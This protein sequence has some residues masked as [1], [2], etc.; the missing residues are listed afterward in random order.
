MNLTQ[1]NRTSRFT[2][3]NIT[4]PTIIHLIPD[5]GLQVSDVIF[6][7]GLNLTNCRAL[8]TKSKILRLGNKTFNAKKLFQDTKSKLQSRDSG[9]PSIRVIDSIP[10]D[11]KKQYLCV[12]HTITSQATQHIT[13]LTNANRGLF[14]LFQQLTKEFKYIKAQYPK[15]ENALLFMFSAKHIPSISMYSL[16]KKLSVIPPKSLLSDFNAFDKHAIVSVN[17]INDVS[18]IMP[19]LGVELD[20]KMHMYNQNIAIIPSIMSNSAPIITTQINSAKD[21]IKKSEEFQIKNIS[22]LIN[23]NNINSISS[24]DSAKVKIKSPITK[25]LPHEKLEMN[26]SQLSDILNKYK[27][28]DVAVQNNIKTAIDN[29]LDSAELVNDEDLEL[30]ILRAAHMTIFGTPDLNK[31]YI[32]NPRKLIMKLEDVNTFSKDINIPKMVMS[33]YMLDPAENIGLKQITGLVRQEYEFSDNI[34]VNI[35]KLF[36]ALENRA[37]NPIKIVDFKPTYQDN[38]LNRVIDYEVTLKNQTGGFKDEYKV[39]IKVPALVND[40]Y[41][42]LNG[43]KYILSNQQ[44]FIPVTKTKSD[45]CRLLT[46]YAIMTIDVVNMRYNLSDTDKIIEYIMVRYPELIKSVQK[47][48]VKRITSVS[49]KNGSEINLI[50][51]PAYSD[52]EKQLVTEHNKLILKTNDGNHTIPIGKSEYIFNQLVELIQTVNPTETLHKTK[53][54]IPYL[55]I[56]M[57]GIKTSLLIYLWQQLGLINALVKLELDY[58]IVSED[59]EIPEKHLAFQ[60]SDGKKLIIKT[61]YKRDELLANG[62]LQIDKKKF[63]FRSDELNDKTIIDSF[64]TSKCGSRAI[65]H[66][67]NN[68]ENMIDPITKEIQEHQDKPTKII[69][70]ILDEMLPKLL[71][72]APNSLTDLNIYRS[73]QAE[74]MFHLMYKNLM[75]A[76]NEYKR[77]LEYKGDDAKLFISDNY[78]VDCLLGVHAHSRGSSALELTQTYSPVAELKSASK[79]IKT[80]YQSGPFI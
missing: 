36:G 38:N 12:D 39:H 6:N 75:M 59:Q 19:I 52:N 32:D 11:I 24:N 31:E 5:F 20:G 22:N 30:T 80:G 54:S 63:Q 64:I 44:Y 7:S 55:Q 60:L 15:Y 43:K 76:H 21:E 50:S 77:N 34:H 40:R 65:Y 58:D 68:T 56:Y 33:D 71:N 48:S 51:E 49:F 74:V 69:N 8:V 28:K 16:L 14:F 73:R 41:F 25:I 70:I 57:S 62:L 23:P 78:I 45:E 3:L 61:I 42:K 27:I 17:D 72:D 1:M 67:N 9:N 66:L 47:D 29:Y 10:D 79:L 13:E 53:K 4:N 26:S 18:M 2:K 46:P 35:K 37:D